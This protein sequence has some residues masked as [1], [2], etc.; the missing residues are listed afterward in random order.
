[1]LILSGYSE[2]DKNAISKFLKEHGVTC[3]PNSIFNGITHI[4]MEKM[5]RSE[6]MLGSIASGRWVLHPRYVCET[7][8]KNHHGPSI[9]RESGTYICTNM[10]I[11]KPDLR[12]IKREA[13]ST[14]GHC[15]HR[16]PG[17]H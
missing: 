3:A 5:S 6:K 8:Q 11:L 17:E 10:N 15:M 14:R 7:L 12:V 9:K 4:V 2:D 13:K 1:M 16:S